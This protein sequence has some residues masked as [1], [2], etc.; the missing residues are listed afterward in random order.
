MIYYCVFQRQ[1]LFH[2]QVESVGPPA[3]LGVGEV[4]G[5]KVTYL[6]N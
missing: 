1:I 4:I 3:L 2:G 5:E 6:L